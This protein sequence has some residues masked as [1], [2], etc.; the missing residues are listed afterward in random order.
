MQEKKEP[1]DF[2]FDVQGRLLCSFAGGLWWFVVVCGGLWWF[3]VICWWF[4]GVCWWFVVVCGHLLVVCGRLLVVC[5]GLWL[6]L[7]I[8]GRLWL[9]PVL[10]TTTNS[11]ISIKVKVLSSKKN[12]R[13]NFLEQY[14]KI[15][16]KQIVQS[17]TKVCSIMHY[18]NLLT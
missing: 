13:E 16:L 7:V 11:F 15:C 14:L 8:C 3:V 9:L 5:G 6:L 12:I 1:S 17:P 4:V 18:Q 10:V 2:W